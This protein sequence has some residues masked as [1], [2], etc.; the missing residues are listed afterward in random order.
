MAS[1]SSALRSRSSTSWSRERSGR[2]WYFASTSSGPGT[3]VRSIQSSTRIPVLGHAEG[4]CHLYLDDSADPAMAAKLA[5]DGKC[6]YP[7]ACNAIETLLVHR[8]FLPRLPR[9]GESVRLSAPRVEPW[10][11]RSNVTPGAKTAGAVRGA[12]ADDRHLAASRRPRVS[13]PS[14][15]GASSPMFPHGHSTSSP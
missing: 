7:S 14:Q 13:R 12:Q 4:V 5:V 10:K 1:G 15:L 8:D 9:V 3:L 2:P 6:D 11:W